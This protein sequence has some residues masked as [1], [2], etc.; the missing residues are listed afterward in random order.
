[1]NLEGY[2]RIGQLYLCPENVDSDKDDEVEKIDVN[3]SN[4]NN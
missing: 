2:E 4:P 1:M 3:A